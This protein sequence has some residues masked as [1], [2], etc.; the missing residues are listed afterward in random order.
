MKEFRIFFLLS[1]I[2]LL[3]QSSPF[4]EKAALAGLR[5]AAGNLGVAVADYDNDGWDDIF[6]S[7]IPYP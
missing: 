2:F 5:T 3:A 6:I 1:P 4:I 7:N